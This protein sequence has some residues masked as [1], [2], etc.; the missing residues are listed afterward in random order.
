VSK[1]N[2]IVVKGEFTEV[3]FARIVALVREMDTVPGRLLQI[4]VLGNDSTSLEDGR[5][6]VE[7]ALPP[8]PDREVSETVAIPAKDMLT[9][10]ELLLASS[11]TCPDCH[12][13]SPLH[14]GPRGGMN[15]NFACPSCGS[16]FNIARYGGVPVWGQRLTKRGEPNISRL[17]SIYGIVL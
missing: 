2:G 4:T 12:P 13:V 10:V 14:E 11:D 1:I 16:E 15:Q 6:I 9:D 7:R 5:A 17:E 8:Q 3:E